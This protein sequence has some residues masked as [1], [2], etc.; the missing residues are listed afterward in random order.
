VGRPFLCK[1]YPEENEMTKRVYAPIGGGNNTVGTTQYKAAEG[2]SLDVGNDV[3]TQLIATGWSYGVQVGTTAQRP[4]STM[5]AQGVDPD[6]VL[7][8]GLKYLDTTLGYEIVY[9]GKV[10]RNPATSAA[11]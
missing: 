4:T 11:V 7:K 5:P 8:K 1:P 6:A 2:T 9:D 3:A 10:W